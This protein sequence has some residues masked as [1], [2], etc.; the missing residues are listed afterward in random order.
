MKQFNVNW[1]EFDSVSKTKVTHRTN[2]SGTWEQLEDMLS[3]T[4]KTSIDK[5]DARLICAAKFV[6]GGKRCAADVI[7]QDIMFLD[8][9]DGKTIDEFRADWP[10][11]K[12]AIYS[13]FNHKVDNG[14]HKFR[15]VMPLDRLVT[16]EEFNDLKD[17]FAWIFKGCDPA[18]FSLSQSFYLPTINELFPEHYEYYANHYGTALPLEPIFAYGR[19]VRAA[20]PPPKPRPVGTAS[21]D[22]VSLLLSKV[23]P[24]LGYDL[25]FRVGAAIR[26]ELPDEEGFQLFLNWSMQSPKFNDTEESLRRRWDG[27]TPGKITLGTL[28]HIA[29]NLAKGGRQVG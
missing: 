11:L 15:V 23:D 14:K 17:G 13:S 10:L 27:F 1:S 5:S 12:Y 2:K 6:S 20:T 28:K 26:T 25:W 19:A 4:P 7:S 3:Q 8:Y 16:P 24:S 18:S 21:F 22:E 29:N 9:D